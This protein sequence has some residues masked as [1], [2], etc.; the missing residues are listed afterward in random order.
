M[1]GEEV[2]KFRELLNQFADLYVNDAF[3][4]SHRKHSSI[5]GSNHE[6]R[7][8]GHLLSK[9]MLYFNKVLTS[10]DTPLAAIVGGSKVSDKIL[11]LENL[12]SRV[13]ILVIGG[14]M[15]NSFAYH[16]QGVDMGQSLVEKDD[17]S[18]KICK[19]VLKLAK[20]KGVK[21]LLPT[22]YICSKNIESPITEVKS[23]LD[24]TDMA[25]DIGPESLKTMV[26]ELNKCKT[27]VWNGPVGMFEKPQF[28]LGTRGILEQV[29]R[30]NASLTSIVCGGDTGS[31]VKAL[32]QES[33]I[34]HVSTG[35]GASLE[36]LEG[37]QLPGLVSLTDA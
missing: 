28:S 6:L 34:D 21:I 3:G 9:E 27:V 18:G 20:E 26:N 36:L 22:D 14:A 16:V 8:A 7:A 13:N 1:S 23:T 19:N 31:A 35:G 5:V 4:C 30:D 25:M 11:L 37:K 29:M 32:G 24:E 17:N 2:K 12:I 33:W 15:A 10:P